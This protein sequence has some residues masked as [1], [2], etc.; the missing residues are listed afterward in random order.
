MKVYIV[1]PVTDA[2]WGGANQFLRMLRNGLRA[3]GCYAEQPN[4]ADAVLFNSH[5]ELSEV[6]ALRRAF[7][8]TLFIHRIDGPLALGRG[9]AGKS[10]DRVSFSWN[11]CFADGTVFQSEWSR[12]ECLHHG[13]VCSA[14]WHV[15]RNAAD[16][17][18]FFPPHSAR[19][20]GVIRVIS[21]SWS[22][23]M[24]KGF[25]V[26]AHL[27]QHLDPSRFELT[28]VGN[29]PEGFR[30]G[31]IR[32]VPPQ[33]SCQLAAMLRACDIY[34][35]PF[36]NDA[37]SNAIAEG[38]QCGLFPVVRRSGGNLE[39]AGAEAEAFDTAADAIPALE[40]ASARLDWRA[41]N[42][43]PACRD[44]VGEYQ[45]FIERVARATDAERLARAGPRPAAVVRLHAQRLLD[46]LCRRVRHVLAGAASR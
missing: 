26:L 32:H 28:F 15:I 31:R 27:G 44:V 17:S 3:R 46:R 12:M 7:P 39:V 8:G 10:V 36:C 29:A 16:P 24:R 23:N 22:S 5:H 20:R 11:R 21:S 38:V 18:I 37:C 6:L 4:L 9:P 30:F 42:I 41:R 25:D 33:P 13:L 35:G 2:P 43:Q 1:Y 40:R 34:L 45:T 14:H 19:A